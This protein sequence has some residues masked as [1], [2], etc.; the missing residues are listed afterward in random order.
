MQIRLHTR[1]QNPAGERVR[2]A[3]NLK[4]IAYEYVVAAPVQS[5][6]YRAI[7]PQGLLPTLEI[8]GVFLAQ[9]MAILELLEELL[10]KP[11]LLPAAPI[12]RARVRGFATH[13]SADL[14]PVN[15]RRIRHYL[16][17]EMGQPEA[18]ILA[19]YRHW[20]AKTFAALEATLANRD[21][22]CPFCFAERP[23]LAWSRK[24]PMR[25]ASAATLKPTRCS[26]RS[27]GAAATFRPLSRPPRS[28]RQTTAPKTDCPAAARCGGDRRC[29]GR[30]AFP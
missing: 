27:T 4:G 24:W 16:Q 1:Y 19:W 30:R 11:A 13:I 9:S 7:N 12:D 23:M 6:D 29:C 8:D 25:G 5:P 10:P 21:L 15:N 18:A 2:I 28:S 3:L 17:T 26:R 20:V 14:H 22:A